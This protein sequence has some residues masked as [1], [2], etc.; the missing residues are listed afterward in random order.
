MQSNNGHGERL[1]TCEFSYSRSLRWSRG[2]IGS[3]GIPGRDAQCGT[4]QGVRASGHLSPRLIHVAAVGAQM[5]ACAGALNGG[6]KQPTCS[7]CCRPRSDIAILQCKQAAS[8]VHGGGDAGPPS[9]DG[10]RSLGLDGCARRAASANAAP[11]DLCLGPL[12]SCWTMSAKRHLAQ[13]EAYRD[14][15]G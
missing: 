13:I 11:G 3:R 1:A 9:S 8:D 6:Q 4:G 2:K 12:L 15:G 5:L 14:H 7:S 10:L